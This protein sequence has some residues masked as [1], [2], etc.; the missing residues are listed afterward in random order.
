MDRWLLR[1]LKQQKER[2]SWHFALNNARLRGKL[3]ASLR[4]L[5]VAGRWKASSYTVVHDTRQQRVRSHL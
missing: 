4:Y 5:H 1:P 3:R 2:T